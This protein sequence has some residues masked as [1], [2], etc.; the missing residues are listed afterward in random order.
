MA[1]VGGFPGNFLGVPFQGDTILPGPFS[2]S[3]ITHEAANIHGLLFAAGQPPPAI[4]FM[5]SRFGT[6][7]ARILPSTFFGNVQIGGSGFA[8]GP[9]SPLSGPIAGGQLGLPV[10]NAAV[11][12]FGPFGIPQTLPA[13]AING[14]GIFP[15]PTIFTANG[16]S[17]FNFGGTG[18]P[19]GN[20]G[21]AQQAALSGFGGGFGGFPVQNAA[22]SNAGFGAGGFGGGFGG[23]GQQ[24]LAM[25]FNG[26]PGI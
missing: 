7:G 16:A 9:F 26:F 21:L 18:V 11:P 22:F 8:N 23:F 20:P 13:A 15:T 2:A 4:E 1:I 10:P 19:F 12:G 3:N 24:P 17:N 5:G 14:G 25:N 6:P